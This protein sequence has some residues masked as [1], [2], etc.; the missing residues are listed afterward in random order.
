MAQMSH[1]L[2]TP[3]NAVIGF[4]EVM[5]R[6]LYGPLGNARYQEYARHISDS[7]DR[8]LKSSEEALAVTEA[9][10]ALMADRMQ[11]RREKL[12]AAT[13]VRQAWRAATAGRDAEHKLTTASCTTQALE[14]LLRE[15]IRWTPAGGTVEVRAA[16]RGGSRSLE[17]R[18]S[19]SP[20]RAPAAEGAGSTAAAPSLRVR[21]PQGLRGAAGRPPCTSRHRRTA[22]R[23]KRRR[24]VLQSRRLGALRPGH[25]R[26]YC[27]L[28]PCSGSS[29]RLEPGG[30]RA[31][32]QFGNALRSA[33]V[34]LTAISA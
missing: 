8:L 18:V 5:L 17:I 32:R 22:R 31:S 28:S 21:M 20:A 1:E 12:M 11:S 16:R 23:H 14:H 13:L 2:R 25:V 6:E 9:M 24:I 29:S 4:S 19:G 30:R 10:S 7:G 33:G 3:L 26:D 27:A 34:R 15:A